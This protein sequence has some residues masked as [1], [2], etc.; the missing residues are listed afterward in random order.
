MRRAQDVGALGHEV[1]AAEHDVV[2]FV[3]RGR[4]AGELQRVADVIGEL[5]HFVAL[6]VMPEDDDAFA[7]RRFCS[8]DA[9]IELIVRKAE[10]A[11]RQRL[12][13]ADALLLEVGEYS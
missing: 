1:H 7:E 2:G 11:F 13:L 3:A 12:A 10:K 6:I 9:G 4:R 8:R 5:D